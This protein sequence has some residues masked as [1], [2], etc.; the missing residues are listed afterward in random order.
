[1]IDV[2]EIAT[3]LTN[4]TFTEIP[5]GAIYRFEQNIDT[6]FMN[7][8]KNSTPIKGLYFASACGDPG[9]GFTGVMNHGSSTIG[10]IM[11]DL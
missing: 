1:M 6:S 9:G 2:M 7:R 5:E 8:I 3:P 4:I 11:H 10:M